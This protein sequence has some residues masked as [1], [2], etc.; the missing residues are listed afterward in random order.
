MRVQGVAFIH[1]HLSGAPD[2]LLSILMVDDEAWIPFWKYPPLLGD[3]K[4]KNIMNNFR[5][6]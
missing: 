3:D 1:G 6:G 5:D 4:R 2:L